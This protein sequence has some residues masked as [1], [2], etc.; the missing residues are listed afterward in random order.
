LTQALTLYAGDLLPEDQYEEW[1]Q[2]RRE[3]LAVLRLEAEL[4]LAGLLLP[5]GRISSA[6]KRLEL[7][8]A[9]DPACEEAY[10]MLMRS[11]AQA[12]DVRQAERASHRC[13]SALHQEIGTEPSPETENL[14]RAIASGELRAESESIVGLEPSVPAPRERPKL[15][16][17]VGAYESEQTFGRESELTLIAGWL[18]ARLAGRGPMLLLLTGGMGVG[19]SHLARAAARHA[20]LRGAAVLWGG[21]SEA[22]GGGL[23]QGFVEALD[24]VF[25]G[26]SSESDLAVA[27]YPELADLLPSVRALRDPL[28]GTGESA[29]IA[30][31]ESRRARLFSSF[32]RALTDLEESHPVFLVLDD[33]HEADAASTE[34][35]AYILRFGSEHRWALLGTFRGPRV[36]GALGSVLAPLRRYQQAQELA[37]GPLSADAS[38][39]LIHSASPHGA[40][41]ERG[42]CGGDSP[43]GE[44]VER[45]HALALGNPLFSLEL[46]RG[47]PQSRESEGSAVPRL[48]VDLVV[49]RIAS[50]GPEARAFAEA[51]SVLG[52]PWD[53]NEIGGIL[54]TRDHVSDSVT[55]GVQGYLQLL[56]QVETLSDLGIIVEREDGFALEHPVFRAAVYNAMSRQRRR[57]LHGLAA[58]SLGATRPDDDDVLA[59]HY[60]LAGDTNGALRHLEPAADRAS[61]LYANTQAESLYRRALA[62]MPPTAESSDR[63]RIEEKLATV[64][65]TMGRLSEAQDLLEAALNRAEQLSDRELG[66]RVIAQLGRV[67]RS[68]GRSA[69]AIPRLEEMQR[70][71]V[72]RESVGLA[73]VAS[74]LAVLYCTVGRY[75]DGVAAAE[76][77]ARLATAMNDDKLLADATLAGSTALFFLGR[78]EEGKK[79]LQKAITLGERIGNLPL[80]QVALANSGEVEALQ[81]EL[82]QSL[83]HHLQALEIVKQTG[84]SHRLAF[85]ESAVGVGLMMVGPW[86]EART[87]LEKARDIAETLGKSWYSTYPLIHLARLELYSG[88][89]RSAERMVNR[90]LEAAQ[91]GDDVQAQRFAQALLA[92]C[93]LAG[94]RPQSAYE[95]LVGMIGSGDTRGETD[96]TTLLS[97]LARS[98][99]SLGKKTDALK[100]AEEAFTRSEDEGAAAEL[101]EALIVLGRVF[102]DDDAN[103]GREI[104]D[105]ALAMAIEMDDVFGQG[106]AHAAMALVCTQA[107]DQVAAVAHRRQAA[108]IFKRLG[109]AS[110][111]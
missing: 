101:M 62:L 110:T 28:Q 43:F 4:S 19:K 24:R 94:Q 63:A 92:E 30:N 64:L 46:S 45:I 18:D 56:D 80:L 77:A 104:L 67:C 57:I 98:L 39:E 97:L 20:Y 65:F 25:A 8:I 103:R 91:S 5:A 26:R 58:R 11:F 59:R 22:I 48:L 86:Q 47:E 17:P 31:A 85:A 75:A 96:V 54:R 29:R 44:R 111:I 15:P 95:R 16:S 89:R 108:R 55:Q 50:L 49:Q 74:V 6:R 71:L 60:D 76:N 69:E 27:E 40:G 3:Q 102:A 1:T 88:R 70:R 33:L 14:Q 99:L 23:Y 93:D 68:A 12:G 36:T 72:G 81:G 51:A 105:R 87:R 35:L 52:D 90:A 107:G 79:G 7:A 2:V 83:D 84:D 32:A 82:A 34:L 73:R 61:G 37:V 41:H 106:R 10:R 100:A 66:A 38:A 42:Q 21:W 78:L 53:L 13:R 9:A 109:A